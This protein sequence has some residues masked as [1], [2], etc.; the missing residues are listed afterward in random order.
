MQPASYTSILN[1]TSGPKFNRFVYNTSWAIES[2]QVVPGMARTNASTSAVMVRT[3]AGRLVVANQVI[4]RQSIG[5]LRV[6]WSDTNGDSWQPAA[7]DIR[8]SANSNYANLH[9]QCDA[10]VLPNDDIALF[11]SGDSTAFNMQGLMTLPS[12]ANPSSGWVWT[13]LTPTPGNNLV[14]ALTGAKEHSGRP[15]S[16]YRADNGT[17]SDFLLHLWE[18]QTGASWETTEILTYNDAIAPETTGA[19]SKPNAIELHVYHEVSQS[20]SNFGI[21]H[22]SRDNYDPWSLPVLFWSNGNKISHLGLSPVYDGEQML[23]GADDTAGD[24]ITLLVAYMPSVAIEDVEYATE[25]DTVTLTAVS[26]LSIEDVEYA[27][28][29]DSVE[30]VANLAVDDVEYATEVDTVTLVA[31]GELSIEDVEYA[32]EVDSVTLVAEGVLSIEDVEYATEV[33]TVTLVSITLLVEDVEWATEVDAV[34]LGGVEMQ[35]CGQP[36]VFATITGQPN[37]FPAVFRVAKSRSLLIWV[38]T[39]T[40]Y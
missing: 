8:T 1:Q 32:T 3:A 16:L 18:N 24:V 29:V 36:H 5:R 13:Q 33:D 28:E 7:A 31:V 10:V 6:N 17:G 37:I 21:Y 30:L 4:T 14:A 9:G 35:V 11:W 22:Q 26:G 25:V 27:T 39:P 40:T 20:D 12:G 19:I 2:D 38:N 23:Y 15:L 34:N